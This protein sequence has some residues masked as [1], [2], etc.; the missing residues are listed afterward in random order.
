MTNA[1]GP[2]NNMKHAVTFYSENLIVMVQEEVCML[3]MAIGNDGHHP[4]QTVAKKL[5]AWRSLPLLEGNRVSK[6]VRS[7]FGNTNHHSVNRTQQQSR[8]VQGASS[9]F[10]IP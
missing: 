1:L 3:I 7:S 10:V 9:S 5:G 8:N 2:G 6:L 4:F